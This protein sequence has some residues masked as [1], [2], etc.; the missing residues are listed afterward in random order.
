MSGVVVKSNKLSELRGDFDSGGTPYCFA[1]T[2][3]VYTS[4]G[5]FFMDLVREAVRSPEAGKHTPAEVVEFCHQI[6]DEV[7]TVLANDT[8]LA[9][10]L[11]GEAALRKTLEK[12]M[13]K[14]GVTDV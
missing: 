2:R 7:F 14:K 6:A 11:P 5:E 13:M 9:F 3:L 12:K 1:Y 8:G 10:T 4:K